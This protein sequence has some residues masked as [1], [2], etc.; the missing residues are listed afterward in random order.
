MHESLSPSLHGIN[1][2]VW[3]TELTRKLGRPAAVDDMPD[4]ELVRLAR[5]GFD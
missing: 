5:M 2:R 3:L 1:T 4:A